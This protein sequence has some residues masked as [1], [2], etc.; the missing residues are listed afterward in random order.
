MSANLTQNSGGFRVPDTTALAPPTETSTS[1]QTNNPYRQSS[2]IPGPPNEQYP[3]YDPPSYEQVTLNSTI[4][5]PV[6]LAN[7]SK[8]EPEALGLVYE[9]QPQAGPSTT[10]TPLQASQRTQPMTTA[11]GSPDLVSQAMAKMNPRDPLD[12][13]PI[14][15]SRIVPALSHEI[16][17]Q[18]LPQPLVIHAKPGKKFLDDAFVTTGTPALLKHDVLAEDWVRLLEDIHIVA[19]LTAGQKITAGI[20]PVTMNVG[21]SG[22]LIS[23]AIEKGMRNKNVGNVMQ[24]LQIWNE[25]FFKPRHLE[26]IVCR[27]DYRVSTGSKDKVRLPAPDRPHAHPRA[28]SH[29]SSSSS[30]SSSDSEHEPIRRGLSKVERRQMKRERR[31][32][33]REQ[34]QSRREERRERKAY[35]K[36]ERRSKEPYRLVVVSI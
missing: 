32:E 15:F 5:S 8:R 19:R 22:F 24:L 10:L 33:R 16:T 18:T 1:F 6:P 9:D 28:M 29:S 2:P 14:C 23:R 11:S 31:A 21:F 3:S 27:G 34:R 12:P 17:Y 35:R 30:S 13:P 36:E 25:R 4:P 7:D 20:L 26:I